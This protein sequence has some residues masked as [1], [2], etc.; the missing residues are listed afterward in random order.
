MEVLLRSV[1]LYAALKQI[2]QSVQDRKFQLKLDA[3]YRRSVSCLYVE[4]T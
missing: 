3:V 1:V 4:V 2:E